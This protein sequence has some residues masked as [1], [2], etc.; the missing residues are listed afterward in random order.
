MMGLLI[1]FILIFCFS[2]IA[3]GSDES[4]VY[5]DIDDDLTTYNTATRLK[6]TPAN[7][8]A[9]ISIITSEDILRQNYRTVPEALIH[10]PGMAVSYASGNQINIQ[11]HG[12][13]TYIPRRMQVLIDGRS[14]YQPGFARVDWVPFPVSIRGFV[15]VLIVKTILKL[16]NRNDSR[17]YSCIS[18]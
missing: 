11:Y 18:V 5:I 17:A 4:D 3:Y 15:R 13:S 8:P 12:S 10:V 9:A 7:T 14:I 6:Q 16:S 1:K 2:S